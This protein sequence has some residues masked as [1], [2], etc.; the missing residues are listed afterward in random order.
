[1]AHIHNDRTCEH[2]YGVFLSPEDMARLV[3]LV[4][5][6][7]GKRPTKAD[8]RILKELNACQGG[9]E[10]ACEIKDQ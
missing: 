8:L 1:M 5:R 3:K 10:L 2:R 4:Q 6:T 7:T 9:R